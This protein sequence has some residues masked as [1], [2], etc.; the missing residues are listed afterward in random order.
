MDRVPSQLIFNFAQFCAE[1]K[2]SNFEGLTESLETKL[3]G[4]SAIM[5]EKRF[6]DIDS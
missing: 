4:L 3:L 5:K 1:E 2:P 6:V